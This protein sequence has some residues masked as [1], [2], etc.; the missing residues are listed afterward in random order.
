MQEKKLGLGSVVATGV[1]LVV[2]TTCLVSLGQGA[3]SIGSSFVIAMVVAGILNLITAMSIA[4]LNAL[5]PNLSGG[6][7]QYTLACMGPFPTIVSM[8]GGYLVCNIL[9]ASVESSLFSYTVA[10]VFSLQVPV[11]VLSGT[12]TVILIVANLFGVD[13]FAKIQNMAAFLLITSMIVVGVIGA[14]KLGTGDIVAQPMTLTTNFP[15]IMGKSAVAFWLFIGIEYIIPIAKDVKNPEKNIPRG[16]FISLFVVFLMQAIMVFGFHNYTAWAE[17]KAA[18]A[19]HLLYGVNLLGTV[20]KI[21]MAV[22]SVLAS[23]STLNSVINSLSKI[24]QGMS[25]LGLLPSVFQKKNRRGAPVAGIALV[26]GGIL[27]VQLSGFAETESVSFLLLAASVLWMISYVISHANVLILRRRL[28]KAPRTFRVPFGALLP[29]VGIAGT[30]YMILN[31]DSDPATRHRIWMLSV[32]VIAVLSIYAVAW[33]KLK[34]QR[35]IFKSYPVSEVM[36][37]ENELYQVVQKRER[38]KQKKLL[39]AQTKA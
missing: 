28:P 3:G 17:L 18:S 32:I 16:M 38:E 13:M 27:L 36:A 14:C 33:I 10:E 1:G 24:T 22:V 9:A 37:M 31:I 12:L 15:E 29:L 30:V 6:L 39:A 4:E 23:I 11:F 2:A 25:K 34:M 8:I 20:G 21:W 7:A 26:G 19:P 35:P 5:M